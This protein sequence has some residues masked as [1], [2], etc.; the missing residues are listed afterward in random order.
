MGKVLLSM[1]TN[2]ISGVAIPHGRGTFRVFHWI[3]RENPVIGFG[4]LLA[5]V[6]YG[7][8]RYMNNR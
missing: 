5:I 6:L 2:F 4:I 8:Y 7:I 3:F 1:L